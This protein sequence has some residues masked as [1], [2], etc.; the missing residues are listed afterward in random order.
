MWTA[1]FL[2]RCFYLAYTSYTKTL[3][4]RALSSCWLHR[5]AYMSDK[6]TRHAQ[7]ISLLELLSTRSYVR[8]G[9]VMHRRHVDRAWRVLDRDCWLRDRVTIGWARC[10]HMYRERQIYFVFS[11]SWRTQA[12]ICT[13]REEK[14]ARE[15]VKDDRDWVATWREMAMQKV[16]TGPCGMEIGQ[17]KF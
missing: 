3:P 12:S 8:Y 7:L 13:E 6:D 16:V 9:V 17:P 4:H 14:R 1:K 15:T 5:H 10:C 11:V 2:Q